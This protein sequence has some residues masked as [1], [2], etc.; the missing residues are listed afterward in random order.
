MSANN[1]ASMLQ[2]PWHTL[3]KSKLV[4]IS[5]AAS[6]TAANRLAVTCR[7]LPAVTN[8]TL[9]ALCPNSSHSCC[10][11]AKKGCQEILTSKDG[12]FSERCCSE[13][14]LVW[15]RIS[16]MESTSELGSCF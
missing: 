3:T 2:P 11:A 7:L 8:K 10:S 5:C 6:E 14:S 12:S 1:V 9:M 13:V 16:E 4:W 15:E